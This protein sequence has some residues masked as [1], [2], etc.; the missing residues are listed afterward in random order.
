MTEECAVNF[1]GIKGELYPR[2]ARILLSAVAL[3]AAVNLQLLRGIGIAFSLI[4]IGLL[5]WYIFD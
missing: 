5:I 2:A 3:I 1:P 4:C